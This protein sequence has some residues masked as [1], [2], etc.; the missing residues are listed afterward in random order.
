MKQNIFEIRQRAQEL[1]EEAIAMW[2]QG[3]QSDQLEGLA[4]DPVFSMLISAIAYQNS[5]TEDEISRIEEEVVREFVSQLAPYEMGHPIPAAIAIQAVLESGCSEMDL[6]SNIYAYLVDNTYAFMPLIRSR[7]LNANI[8]SIVRLDGRR[9]KVVIN[10]ETP[11]SD[12]SR[13]CFAIQ[14]SYFEDVHITCNQKLLPLI[15]PWQSSKFPMTRCFSHD[16]ALY[17]NSQYFNASM[18]GMELFARQ[19]LRMFCIKDHNPL[20]YLPKETDS[21]EFIFEFKGI[22][23]GF[24]FDYSQL[25]LNS[26]V[27][28]EAQLNYATLSN[29]HP[30]VRL[31]GYDNSEEK[32]KMQQ[33]LH[34]VRPS[35]DQLFGDVD[36]QV[37]RASADR[38]NRASLAR[39]LSSLIN[40]YHSDFYAFQQTEELTRD[41]VM[42]SLYDILQHLLTAS[43]E[44]GGI[45]VGTYAMLNQSDVH[46]SRKISV[47]LPYLTTHGASVNALLSEDMHLKMPSRFD[48]SATRVIAPPIPGCDEITNSDVEESLMRYRIVTNNRV[49]TPADIKLFCY[50]ELKARYS[51]DSNMIS[52]I[53]VTPR[54]TGFE[55]NSVGYEIMTEIVL[56]E[57]NYVKRSFE[58]KI[59]YVAQLLEKMMEIR[60][61]S[62]YPIRVNIS[63][64]ETKE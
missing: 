63:I 10:F 51:I 13:F 19:N 27:L 40:K 17:N 31:A 20:E 56:K 39:L 12:L 47:D 64:E 61:T 5:E 25:L 46:S 21:V 37:R 34:L 26:V 22:S 41:N 28:V 15:R 49:V 38:F 44:E 48:N 29:D 2:Q 35:E 54:R 32:G 6:D 52:S 43:I 33:F 1:V 30:I 55:H 14:N 62:I 60:T 18:I 4:K 11:I 24:T 57:S 7:V 50:T 3:S 53:D 23:E 58:D 8:G 45:T 42:E 59:N 16:C 36:I 9:W